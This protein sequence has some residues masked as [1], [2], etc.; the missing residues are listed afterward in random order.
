M[1]NSTGGFAELD[2][3]YL[4]LT[5]ALSKLGLL[6]VHVLDHSAIGAPPVPAELKAQLRAAFKGLFILAGGYDQAS[7]ERALQA[8]QA[9]LIAFARLFLANPDLVARMRAGAPLNPPDMASF[10]T[11]GPKGYTDYP[12]LAAG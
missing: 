9:D 10:Y 4:S 1:F 7:A 3:Q 8:G 11:P 12:M 2:A 5:Q 6:Y